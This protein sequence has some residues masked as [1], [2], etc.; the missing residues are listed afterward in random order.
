MPRV[1]KFTEI[2]SIMVIAGDWGWGDLMSIEFQFC[3]MKN[4]GDGLW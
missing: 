3:N 1:V 2:E 4:S